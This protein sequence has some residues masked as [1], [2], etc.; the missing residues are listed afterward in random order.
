MDFMLNE[1][2]RILRDTLAR[3]MQTAPR[4]T[5]MLGRWR[6]LAEIGALGIGFPED[7]G[8]LGGGLREMEILLNAAGESRRAEPLIDALAIPG[9]ALA[10]IDAPRLAELVTGDEMTIAAFA[11]QTDPVG[12]SPETELRNGALTGRKTLVPGGA[13]ASKALVSAH[14]NGTLVLAEVT[15]GLAPNQ[16]MMDGQTGL[17]PEFS[18]VPATVL[19]RGEAAEKAIRASWRQGLHAIGVQALG[20][21]RALFDETLAYVRVREQFGKPIGR[22]QVIQHRMADMSIALEEARAL[23]DMARHSIKD[24]GPDADLIMARTG[25]LDRCLLV[26][27]EAIQ[28]HGGIGM[29]EEMPLGSGF[30]ALKV[31]QGRLGGE[32]YNQAVLRAAS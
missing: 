19:A 8:G 4:D 23:I 27:R 14:D 12:V 24:D 2:Q 6:A 16:P 20:A 22:F 9:A 26:G 13:G 5:E 18:A 15:L 21:A 17:R 1:E 3:F 29:S 30:R 31:L 10:M 11:E 7:Q 25:V 32:S 28:L